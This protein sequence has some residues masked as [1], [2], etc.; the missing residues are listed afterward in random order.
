MIIDHSLVVFRRFV[1]NVFEVVNVSVANVTSSERVHQDTK[2]GLG[3]LTK[4]LTATLLLML[5]GESPHG[6]KPDKLPCV[7]S[8]T[9]PSCSPILKGHSTPRSG[10]C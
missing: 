6:Y 8:Y 2:F 5:L 10:T 9:P 4:A 1:L 3:S 7:T